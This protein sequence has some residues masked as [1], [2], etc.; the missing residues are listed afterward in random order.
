TSI[1]GTRDFANSAYYDRYVRERG[2]TTIGVE[3]FDLAPAARIARGVREKLETSSDAIFLSI[4]IDS[5][6]LPGSSAA[7]PG[8]LT[9]REAIAIVREIAQSPKLI[10]T[11]L[12]ELSPPWDVQNVTAKLA[13]RLFLE[14][15]A[16]QP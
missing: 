7:A 8:T 13:A 5:V 11:D 1:L 14:T 12:S 6:E 10:G 15:I 3:A 2:I 16:A 4:D 9:P